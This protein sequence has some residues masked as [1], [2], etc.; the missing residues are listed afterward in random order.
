MVVSVCVCVCVCVCGE[1]VCA[2][3]C[4]RE[5]CECTAYYVCLCENMDASVCVLYKNH[6]CIV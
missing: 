5:L 6:K 3:K 1:C 2:W 4:G